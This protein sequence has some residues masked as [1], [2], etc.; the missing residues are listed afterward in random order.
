MNLCLKHFKD[1]SS[2]VN[3]NFSFMFGWGKNLCAGEHNI[4]CYH[5]GT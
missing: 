2:Y 4:I 5:K 3:F 1:S